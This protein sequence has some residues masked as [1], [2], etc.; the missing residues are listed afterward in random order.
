[1]STFLEKYWKAILRS[2]FIVFQTK[3]TPDYHN[4]VDAL[5]EVQEKNG[6]RLFTASSR[7]E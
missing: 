5:F 6:D 4:G 3:P 2:F 1:M 7:R